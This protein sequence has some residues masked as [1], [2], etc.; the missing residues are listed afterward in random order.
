MSPSQISASEGYSSGNL[1]SKIIRRLLTWYVA[2]NLNI[3]TVI[4]RRE[5]NSSNRDM[6]NEKGQKSCTKS[7]GDYQLALAMYY[8]TFQPSTLSMNK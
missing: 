5:G 8:I 3:F 4:Y 1:K 2:S 6:K 7:M